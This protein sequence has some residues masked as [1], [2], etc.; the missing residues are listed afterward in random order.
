LLGHLA[1]LGKFYEVPAFLFY[2]RMRGTPSGGAGVIGREAPWSR[3]RAAAGAG[4]VRAA[5]AL[6]AGL[7]S[8]DFPDADVPA[9]PRALPVHG[10][11][12]SGVQP[13]V[14]AVVWAALKQVVAPP[15]RSGGYG[16]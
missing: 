12:P 5:L 9:R 7:P 1:L 4:W 13:P 15:R 11:P 16:V 3:R 2:R 6:G 10:G 14:V 8:P